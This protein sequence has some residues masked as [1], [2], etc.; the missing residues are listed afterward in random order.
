[1]PTLKKRSGK[2]SRNGMDVGVFA[3]VGGQPD[4]VRPR[5]APSAASAWPNGASTRRPAR[6]SPRP[7]PI[8]SVRAGAHA[9]VMLRLALEVR[10]MM[11]SHSR[12]V[13]ADEMRLLALSR[14]VG[15]PLPGR[16]RSTIAFGLPSRRA[17]RAARATIAA[18]S[19]PSISLRLPAEGAPLVGDRLHVEDDRAVGLDAVAVDQRDEVVEP[20]VARR[21][22][23]LPGRALLHLAVGEL[24]E[25]ARRRAVEP[26]AER[27]AD[28]LA[29][30]VAERA[31]DHLD[32]R[33]GVE[34][35]T[36]RAGCR[37]R[38]RWRARRP[39]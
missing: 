10:A 25:D 1:M 36:S 38:R 27:L 32:A 31:A 20:E 28:A 26:Q 9:M 30:A 21:H 15:T 18:M 3:E 35:A 8:A 5:R 23:R 16:V 6:P 4:D 24:D 13:D 37:R 12:G 22:R 2:A 29:E 39:G 7:A 34:R 14:C 17:R 33:R 11:P 19:L